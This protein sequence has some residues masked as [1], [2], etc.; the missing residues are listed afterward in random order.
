MFSPDGE[1][2]L[3]ASKFTPT[4]PA[5]PHRKSYKARV[6]Q[7][8]L[9]AVAS[10]RVKTLK[11]L[12]TPS[13]DMALTVPVDSYYGLPIERDVPVVLRISAVDRSLE[14]P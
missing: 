6:P 13:Y 4:G 7:E 5:G 9:D 1:N 12:I 2:L 14:A 8:V 10:G 3:L 11:L